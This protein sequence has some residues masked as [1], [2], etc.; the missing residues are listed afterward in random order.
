MEGDGRRQRAIL[1]PATLVDGFANGWLV[2]P[3]GAGT[4]SVTL[5]WTPQSGENVA[6]VVS[7]LAVAACLAL[8]LGLR[9]RRRARGGEPVLVGGADAPGASASAVM[10]EDADAPAVANP[11]ATGPG[12]DPG[13]AAV[14][15]A[16]CGLGAGV[17]VP[18]AVFFAVFLGVALGVALTLIVPRARGLL[19]L[20]V[21]GFAMG[22]VVYTLVLQADQHF[23]SGAWPTHFEQANILV[24]IAIVFLGADAVVDLVRRRR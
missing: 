20:A 4:V 6:L 18:Q 17:L 2:E 16:V 21:V 22:G 12:R 10:A 7:A 9:R 14:L 15:A 1:G 8:A 13:L 5:R 23:P 19:G 3:T 24:W 11:F